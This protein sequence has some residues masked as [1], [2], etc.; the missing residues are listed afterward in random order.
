[1]SLNL[2][3]GWNSTQQAR[4][5]QN[6]ETLSEVATK[7]GVQFHVISPAVYEK[8][9]FSAATMRSAIFHGHN[10]IAERFATAEKLVMQSDKKL[11]YLYVPELDQTAHSQGWKS[12]RWLQLLED[13]DSEVSGLAKAL[14]KSS[15][16]LLT[17]DHGVIDI[18]KANHVYLDEIIDA[19]ELDF[20]GGDTRG[21]FLYLK[22]STKLAELSQRLTEHLGDKC[23]ILT[24]EQLV[25]AGYWKQ[26]E[27]ELL[28]P[29]IVLL[30]KKEVALYH[31]D[32]AKKKSLEM[33][34]HHGSISSVE[35]TIPLLRIGF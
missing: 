4:E 24:P 29:E 32:F 17:A 15:G 19:D 16:I 2:L 12:D 35:M 23:Y 26:G 6:L 1:M 8:S 3:S 31:R 21:L 20:V 30:A 5:F 14:S 10:S 11:I 18:Q 9:G 34:G 22:D 27:R 7:S 28:L 13:L 33:I 25:S